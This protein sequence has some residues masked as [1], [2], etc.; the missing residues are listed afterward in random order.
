MDDLIE[1]GLRKTAQKLVEKEKKI[2]GDLITAD[3]DGKV[4]KVP[5]R[6]L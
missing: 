2:D 3:K 4:K 5:A 6:D 1:E